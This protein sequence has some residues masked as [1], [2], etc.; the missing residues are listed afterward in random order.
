VFVEKATHSQQ[1]VTPQS[2]RH[3]H[4]LAAGPMLGIK[5]CAQGDVRRVLVHD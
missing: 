3:G 1:A 5:E 4:V 2:Q